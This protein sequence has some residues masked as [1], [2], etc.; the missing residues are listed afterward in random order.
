MGA[1]SREFPENWAQDELTK[2]IDQ[3]NTNVV[4]TY[5]KD[6]NDYPFVSSIDEIFL[7]I[8]RA[9]LNPQ[10]IVESVILMRSHVA[11][12]ATALLAM[13]GMNPEAFVQARSCLENSLYALHM[14]RNSGLDEVWLRRHDN[15]GSLQKTKNEFNFSKVIQTLESEDPSNAKV[16]RKL[17]ERTIDFGAHPNERSVTANLSIIDGNGGIKIQQTY[18]AGGTPTQRHS[19]KTTAQVGLCSLYIFRLIFRERFD[20]LGL[21]ERMDHHRNV[22]LGT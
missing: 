14:N 2:F 17:Y 22:L 3:V 15:K 19:M 12:R 1:Q 18:L 21:T 5:D 10:A 9:L 13:A 4:A 16:A 11:Y 7:N 8:V 20:I 6:K